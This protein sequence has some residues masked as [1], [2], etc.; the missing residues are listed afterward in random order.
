M[1]LKTLFTYLSTIALI[2]TI[3]L[4]FPLAHCMD[5]DGGMPDLEELDLDPDLL[6][7]RPLS[8]GSRAPIGA[9]EAIVIGTLLE[10][11]GLKEPL[12]IST[13][14]EKG[15]DILYLM[16]SKIS[17]IEYG[18]G[19]CNLF[20]NMTSKMNLTGGNLL[21]IDQINRGAIG[22]IANL[23]ASIKNKDEVGSLLPFAKKITIQERKLGSYFQAGY[24]K[25]AF[26]LQFHTSLQLGERNFYL[27]KNDRLEIQ[28]LNSLVFG[29]D[30]SYDESNLYRI[31]AGMGDTRVKL[32]L[33]A[34]NSK[35]LQTDVGMECI[36]PTSRSSRKFLSAFDDTQLNDDTVF[37]NTA[38][39]SLLNV[40]D[41][42]LT[43]EIGN[44]GHFGLGF[45]MES[46]FN[47]F[48]NLAELVTRVSFDKFFEADEQ[49]LMIQKQSGITA[50]YLATNPWGS[51][52]EAQ[53]AVIKFAKEYLI[54]LPYKVSTEPGGIFNGIMILNIPYKKWNFRCG[55]DFYFQQA[56]RFKHVYADQEVQPL[57]RTDLA[58]VGTVTQ[59]KISSET[60]YRI[61]NFNNI[62]LDIGFGGD[63]TIASHNIGKDWT[64]YLKFASEF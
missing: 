10:K 32:G 46:K 42:L 31:R 9:L 15:R 6:I 1:K 14:P 28:A 64:I 50:N 24:A 49:R 16:P 61:K 8:E 45:Y 63:T 5:G 41:Y 53:T 44:G 57:L 18:G 52:T 48:K 40:R 59:H 3:S 21:N 43:P 17:A 39:N 51:D 25:G 2:S 27:N 20:F 23:S 33:N 12:W 62:N 34:L 30:Q 36:I 55:Y 56:E 22:H 35:I 38:I 29:E 26:L 4:T 47:L 37:F 7:D 11:I 13:K 54:P 19:S 58:R 60:T